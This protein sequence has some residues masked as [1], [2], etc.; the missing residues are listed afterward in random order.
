MFTVCSR[1]MT[2][3]E[4]LRSFEELLRLAMMS[5]GPGRQGAFAMPTICPWM[6]V[7]RTVPRTSTVIPD[8]GNT[9]RY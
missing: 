9:E 6:A 3:S 1:E 8:G 2:G 5:P 4:L 7:P